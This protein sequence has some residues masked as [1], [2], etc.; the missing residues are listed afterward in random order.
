LFGSKA[1]LGERALLIQADIGRLFDPD[2]KDYFLIGFWGHGVN[3]YAFYYVR[4]DSGRRIFFRLPYGGVYMDNEKNAAYIVQFMTRFLEFEEEI[5]QNVKD[6]MAINSMGDEHYRVVAT[7]GRIY[8]CEPSSHEE[9]DFSRI[10]DYPVIQEP[11]DADIA[12][13]LPGKLEEYKQRLSSLAKENRDINSKAVK[14]TVYKIGILESLLQTSPVVTYKLAA[15]LEE[16]YGE[17]DLDIF[18]NAC[19]VVDDYCRTGGKSVRGGTG[20]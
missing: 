16:Q 1:A 3:S 9:I 17:L 12:K 2:M 11:K 4:V 15:K 13:K 19:A 5:G 10:F 18:K 20:L 8:E 7:D 14:D 6:L